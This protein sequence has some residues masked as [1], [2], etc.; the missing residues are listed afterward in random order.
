MLVLAGGKL[1][2]CYVDAVVGHLLGDRAVQ[3]SFFLFCNN[4]GD[5][6]LLRVEVV[7]YGFHIKGFTIICKDGFPC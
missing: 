1:A 4:I 5:F 7:E 6:C 2:A 3:V